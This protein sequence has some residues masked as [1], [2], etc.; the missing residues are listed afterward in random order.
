MRRRRLRCAVVAPCAKASS[1]EPHRSLRSAQTTPPG[2]TSVHRRLTIVAA[3]AVA[4]IV[5]TGCTAQAEQPATT[6]KALSGTPTA[7]AA[8]QHVGKDLQL[9]G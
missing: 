3:V 6:A 8:D 1:S 5:L 4:T 2:G 7:E 9:T